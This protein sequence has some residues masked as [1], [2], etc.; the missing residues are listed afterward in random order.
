MEFEIRGNIHETY[1]KLEEY[2]GPPLYQKHSRWGG[3]DWELVAF[4]VDEVRT[5]KR[6]PMTRVR[7]TDDSQATYILL[8]MM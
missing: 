1:E 7:V 6:T 2:L 8:K 5:W 3:A 4:W